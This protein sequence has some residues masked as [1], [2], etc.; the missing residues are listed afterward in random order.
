MGCEGAGFGVVGVQGCVEAVP[1]RIGDVAGVHVDEAKAL[2]LR[3]HCRR[4]SLNGRREEK[5][6]GNEVWLV[7]PRRKRRWR[8]GTPYVKPLK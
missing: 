8:W 2:N 5:G 3:Y 1:E 4:A 6:G 7:C